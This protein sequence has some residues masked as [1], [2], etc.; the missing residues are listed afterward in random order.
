MNMDAVATILVPVSAA[1]GAGITYAVKNLK[2][3]GSNGIAKRE[4]LT[5]DKHDVLCATRLGE[6]N[7][8]IIEMSDKIFNKLDSTSTHINERIDK[9]LVEMTKK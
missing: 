2:R 8:S 7:K 1:I 3:P 4:L 6:V 9:V 5:S